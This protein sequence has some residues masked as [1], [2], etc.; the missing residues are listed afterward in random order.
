MN[1]LVNCNELINGEFAILEKLIGFDGCWIYHK[2]RLYLK[3]QKSDRLY[4]G[5]LLQISIVLR[6]T[7]ERIEAIATTMLQQTS[8]IAGQGQY[9]QLLEVTRELATLEGRLKGALKGTLNKGKGKGGIVLINKEEESG[10]N[11]PVKRPDGLQVPEWISQHED[12]SE[13][14]DEWIGQ[15]AKNRKK[16]SQRALM[17]N[18]KPYGL[19]VQ[20]LR[21]ALEATI[22]AGWQGIYEPFENR[23]VKG[24]GGGQPKLAQSFLNGVHNDNMVKHYEEK[25]R[26]KKQTVEIAHDNNRIADDK[27]LARVLL[28]VPQLGS[29]TGHNR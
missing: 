7:P 13:M 8:L 11:L 3:E 27:T 4:R 28:A 20:R 23:G 19:D 12:I 26:I 10:E 9:W 29:K 1:I 21:S 16:V 5:K 6:T 24:Q 2:L 15:R 25:E 17:L 14:L 18:L 22:A